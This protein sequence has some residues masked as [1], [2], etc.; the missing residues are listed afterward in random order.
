MRFTAVA[1]FLF[2]ALGVAATPTEVDTNG[3]DARGEAATMI[4]YDGVS[5][6]NSEIS[7]FDV[8]GRLPNYLILVSR[9]AIGAR[10]YVATRSTAEPTLS[11][12]LM[13]YVSVPI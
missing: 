3:F 8:L 13:W 4:T 2:A 9:H 11:I 5:K 10:K 6:Y 12:A 1:V 7:P